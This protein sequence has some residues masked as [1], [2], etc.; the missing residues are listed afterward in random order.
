MGSG[1]LERGSARD[2]PTELYAGLLPDSD[3][4]PSTTPSASFSSVTPQVRQCCGVNF[5]STHMICI[6]VIQSLA[7]GVILGK[8]LNLRASISSSVN[9]DTDANLLLGLC[10]DRVI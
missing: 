8:S 4:F 6:Y 5:G 3:S 10:G 7:S 2:G 9:G 1:G